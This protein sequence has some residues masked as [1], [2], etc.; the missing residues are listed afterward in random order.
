MLRRSFL[1]STSAALVAI[2]LPWKRREQPPAVRVKAQTVE[3]ADYERNLFVNAETGSDANSGR[4]PM[5][6]FATVGR[7]MDAAQKG[8]T[9]IISPGSYSME[10]C[11]LE[12]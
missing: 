7:A 11:S 4:H 12:V 10:V 3:A 9:I 1:K 6:P 2:F 8:D 5:R